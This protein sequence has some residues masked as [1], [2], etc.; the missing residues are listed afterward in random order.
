MEC[1]VA[2][3]KKLRKNYRK[4]TKKN[5]RFAILRRLVIGFYVIAGV[6]ALMATSVLFVFAYDVITQC[7]YFSA[8]IL[9]IEGM[10]RLS[11]NQIIEAAQLRKGMNILDV[12][13]SMV[14]KRLL[15]Q[16]WIADAEIRREI[17]AGLYIKVQEHSPL[18]IIDLGHK[19]LLNENGQIFKEWND[20]DPANLPLVSGLTP[21]DI[22]IHGKNAVQQSAIGRNLSPSGQLHNDPFEA[23][24]QVLRLGKQS[25]SILS[26]RNIRQIQVDREIGITLVA[27]KQIKTIVLGYDNYPHKFNMLNNILSQERRRRSF[28]DFDRID[29]NNVN[30]IVVNPVSKVPPGDHK[31]V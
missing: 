24:M 12:N 9:K 27:F 4:G 15:A 2:R 1:F 14:R 18:A 8:K 25:R 20:T 17:P 30:R 29:L 22:R 19:F 31:E 11:R 28:P 3:Q 7:D 6:A 5:L 16:P 13:L 26:N 23:V 21:S 10:Q